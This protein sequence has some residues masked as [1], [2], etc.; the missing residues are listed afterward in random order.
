L[1]ESRETRS[2][3][4]SS[5]LPDEALQEATRYLGYRSR[6]EAEISKHLRQRGYDGATVERSIERLRELNYL[7][8]RNF[9]RD[10]A[11]AKISRAGYGPQRIAT[12]LQARG[13][14]EALIQD[15]LGEAFTAGTEEQNARRTL[16]ARYKHLNLSDP[17]EQRRAAAFLQR[18]GYSSEV[19]FEILHFSVEQE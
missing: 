11:A 19:I 17:K 7:N 8:D 4:K 15:T 12:E 3:S 18:Q 16:A 10:W 5:K 6:S 13:I 14:A 9:A 2:Q 1:I